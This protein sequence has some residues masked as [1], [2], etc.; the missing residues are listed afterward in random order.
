M[1][2]NAV[3]VLDTTNT[4]VGTFT[5]IQAAVTAASSGDTIRVHDG[6]YD[7][8]VMIDKP[9][10]L[11]SVNG[12][13]STIISGAVGTPLGAIQIRPNVNNVTI[14]GLDQGFTI[15]GLNGNGAIEKAAVYIQGNNSNITIQG[16]ELI[17]NGDSALTSEFAASVTNVLLD[18]NIFSGKTFEGDNPSGVGFGTQFNVGNNAPRQLVVMGNGGSGPYTSSNII[19]SNN[20]ITGTAGGI[21]IDDGV[22][23]Q[24]NNLVTIDADTVLFEGNV[25]T[26][27]TNRFAVSL[28]S[29]GPNSSLI[30]NTF[31]SSAGGGN[32]HFISIDYKGMPGLL[33][34]NNFLVS[35]GTSVSGTVGDDIITT[36]F[37]ALLPNTVLD[38]GIGDD[39]LVLAGGSSTD[40]LVLRGLSDNSAQNFVSGTSLDNV[41]IQNFSQFDLSEF[42][43]QIIFRGGSDDERVIG[44]VGNDI[45]RGGEG[46]DRLEAIAG[47]NILR[48]GAGNDSLLGGSGNDRLVGGQG[49]NSVQG[50]SGN[51]TLISSSGQNLLTGGMGSDTFIFLTVGGQENIIT[52][53]DVAQ[54]Q[55]VVHRQWFG[56]DLARGILDSRQ[57]VLGSLAQTADHRFIYNEQSGEL[58]FDADGS[59]SQAQQLMAVLNN[60]SSLSVQNIRVIG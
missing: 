26:G 12:R 38:G 6:T 10:T 5:T 50:G 11:L 3:D 58:S 31:D 18:N 8:N 34:G 4:L 9:I 36:A 47:N 53:F 22:S 37:D 35:A 28:R 60:R 1:T 13:G 23:A 57:F 20:Q 40:K 55:I 14:G 49:N 2:T 43:G 54:D 24:G 41:S 44:G 33:S 30:D 27:F 39:L 48:G 46:D 7:E 17:A 32:S 29:R 51:D 16:N 15:T 19:F 21:S 52:D 45:L 56:G 42:L 25:F 59:G